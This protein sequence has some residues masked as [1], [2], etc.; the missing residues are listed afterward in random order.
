MVPGRGID[1]PPVSAKVVWFCFGP[2][3]EPKETPPSMTG[4]SGDAVASFFLLLLL[5]GILPFF[6]LL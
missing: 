6:F 3:R 1:W 5:C 4:T 2:H